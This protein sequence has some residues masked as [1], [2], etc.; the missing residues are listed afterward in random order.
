MTEYTSAYVHSSDL[1]KFDQV[2][3]ATAVSGDLND[4]CFP[5]LLSVYN[6]L[7]L[8][9]QAGTQWVDNPTP[10]PVQDMVPWAFVK[11]KEIERIE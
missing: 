3:H 10:P 2:V 11:F 9:G 6:K 5:D 1:S 8:V 4:S 7:H